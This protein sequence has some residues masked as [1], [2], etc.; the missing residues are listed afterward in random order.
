MKYSLIDTHCDTASAALDLGVGFFENGLHID[1]AKL[2][3]KRYTQFFAAFI[4]PEYRLSAKKRADSI[5]EKVKSEAAKSGGKIAFCKSFAD[6][7]KNTD[8]ICA[9]LSLEG[10]EAIQTLADLLDLYEQGVRMA[11]LTWN[12]SNHLAGGVSEQETGL[13]DF[14]AK[15][16]AEMNKIG[17]ILDVSHLNDKSFYDVAEVCKKP[18]IAS[19]SN[20]RSV[21]KNMRNLTDDQFLRIKESGGRVGINLYP[22]FLSDSE[23]A[24]IS[25]IIKHI[26][27]FLSLGGEDIIGIGADFD[28]VECLPCKITG[29]CDMDRLFDEMLRLGYKEEL[30]NKIS[31]TNMERFLQE[32]L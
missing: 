7:E 8:K 10:G 20:S 21:C 32:N 25:D 15:V 18:F 16:I 19:H 23:G 14:G 22:K 24:G 4:D 29:V 2:G 3:G 26:E 17:M 5:I 11:T 9:F 13:S 6:Y 27:H 28:G 31:Y 1:L 30:V 12:F